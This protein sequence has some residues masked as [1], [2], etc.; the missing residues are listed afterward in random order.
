MIKK[1]NKTFND[2]AI[3]YF[4]KWLIL[5]CKMISPNLYFV[6]VLLMCQPTAGK[7][8][9]YFPHPQNVSSCT[10]WW[11]RVLY[12]GTPGSRALCVPCLVR[13]MQTGHLEKCYLRVYCPFACPPTYLLDSSLL[14]QV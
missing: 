13:L 4:G 9:M 10:K 1:K 14:N 6:D 11:V 7:M 3:F 12:P 8:G 2:W 5:I